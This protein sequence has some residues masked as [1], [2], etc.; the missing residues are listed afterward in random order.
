ML[1]LAVVASRSTGSVIRPLR[2]CVRNATPTRAARSFAPRALTA[3]NCRSLCTASGT[4]DHDGYSDEYV[5]SV[6]SSCKTIAMVGASPNW[7]R[8]SYFAM[9]YMQVRK[10]AQSIFA[11]QVF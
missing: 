9:K 4:I 1:R 5:K 10:K 3:I 8:P 11:P 2:A 7:N 6:L